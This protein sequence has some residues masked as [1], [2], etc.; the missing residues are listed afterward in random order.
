M[1]KKR[2]LKGRIMRCLFLWVIA[3]R[4][5]HAACIALLVALELTIKRDVYLEISEKE[6]TGHLLQ[7]I[8]SLCLLIVT[9]LIIPALFT[10]A[11]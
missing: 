2:R 9:Y 7:R 6:A 4:L 8:Q 3:L 5:P 10:E 1:K 11:C